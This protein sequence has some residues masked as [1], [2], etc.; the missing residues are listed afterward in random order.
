MSGEEHNPLLPKLEKHP[1]QGETLPIDIAEQFLTRTLGEGRHTMYEGEKEKV[2]RLCERKVSIPGH[3]PAL[4]RVD[5]HKEFKDEGHKGLD[6][7]TVR[8]DFVTE[9]K[10]E[11]GNHERIVEMWWSRS[12]PGTKDTHEYDLRQMHRYTVPEYRDIGASTYAYK[13]SEAWAQQLATLTGRNFTLAFS[14]DQ[15]LTMGWAEKRGYEP[16]PEDAE[17]RQEIKEHPERFDEV[18]RHPLVGQIRNPALDRDGKEVRVWFRK[19]LPGTT[20][21]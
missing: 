14:T 21:S 2:W 12:A 4:L 16:Y 7:E 9:K 18:N 6:F 19:A 11:R 8:F 20:R 1:A 3:G 17:L 15:P 13:V 10:N 5:Y